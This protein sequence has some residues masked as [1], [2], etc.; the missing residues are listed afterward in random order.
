MICNI[1]THLDAFLGEET[2]KTAN[3]FVT[4]VQK[5]TAAINVNTVRM[6]KAFALNRHN[7]PQ[8]EVNENCRREI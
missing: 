2:I 4:T 5:A 3:M 7:P 1:L 8:P 6:L